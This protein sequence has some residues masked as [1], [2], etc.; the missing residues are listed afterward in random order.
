[1]RIQ[2]YDSVRDVTEPA[3]IAAALSKRHGDGINSFWL[4]HGAELYPAI[5][6]MVNGDLASVHYLP[7]DRDA[8]FV[9]IAEVSGL[10]P[11]ETSTFFVGPTEEI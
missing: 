7:K 10:S 8:G 4:S 11:N 2:D 5:N 9:P 1:M 3:D 6:I